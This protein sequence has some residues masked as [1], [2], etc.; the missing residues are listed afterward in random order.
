MPLNEKN[1]PEMSYRRGYQ[2][3]AHFRKIRKTFFYSCSMR[4]WQPLG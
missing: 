3:R 4:T 2:P 1:D